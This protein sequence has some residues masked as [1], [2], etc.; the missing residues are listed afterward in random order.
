[1]CA[2]ALVAAAIVPASAEAGF[3]SYDDGTPSDPVA[4]MGYS[5]TLGIE[6]N[7]VLLSQT[8]TT[9]TVV[10]RNALLLPG[11]DTDAGVV[12]FCS[13]GLNRATCTGNLGILFFSVN[14][15]GGD[16]RARVTSSTSDFTDLA[17]YGGDGRDRLIGSP[18]DDVLGGGADADYIDGGAGNDNINV[19]FSESPPLGTRDGADV[20][21]GGDGDDRIGSRDGVAD[22]VQCGAGTDIA[23]VDSLDTVAADCEQVFVG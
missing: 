8:A 16:D 13:L 22:D 6:A 15:G 10:E 19:S 23:G 9:G 11:P 2:A 14:L 21:R 5:D 17:V 12:R 20:L 7:D 18:D 3:V 4:I 1:M